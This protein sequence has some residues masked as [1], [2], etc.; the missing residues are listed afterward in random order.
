[1]KCPSQ[2]HTQNSEIIKLLDE[3]NYTL[4]TA[5][6]NGKTVVNKLKEIF[7]VTSLINHTVDSKI[8]EELTSGISREIPKF[9]SMKR[10]IRRQRVIKEEA[11]SISTSLECL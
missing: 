3:H 5:K 11:P 8:S 10:A 1:M 6:I 4:N 2:L 9:S 7:Y